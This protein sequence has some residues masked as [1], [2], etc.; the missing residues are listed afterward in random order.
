MSSLRKPETEAAYQKVKDERAKLPAANGFAYDLS[1]EPVIETYQH[2]VIIPAGFPYDLVAETHHMLVPK[3]VFGRLEEANEEEMKEL[4]EIKRSLGSRYNYFL[5]T[6]GA[7][8]SNPVHLHI[9]LIKLK[10][11][12]CEC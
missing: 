3:R 5:E 10:A 2:W 6:L 1:T 9:H 7:M 12:P 4:Y 11:R 8:Q